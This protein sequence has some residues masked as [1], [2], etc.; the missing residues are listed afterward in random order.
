MTVYA[1]PSGREVARV[2]QIPRSRFSPAALAVFALAS[3][4]CAAIS[5]RPS[6][7]AEAPIATEKN[8]PGDIPDSQIFILY[9]SP[10]GFTVEVPEGWGRKERADGASFADKYGLLEVS[11][12]ATSDDPTLASV[13]ANEAM[14]LQQSGHAVKID[15][16]E[17]VKLPAGPAILIKYHSNSEANAVSNKKIRLEH[18]RY[19]IGHASKLATIDFSAPAGADNVDQWQ[20]MSQSFVWN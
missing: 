20:L 11:L 19:L 12:S 18:D 1:R 6:L 5:P 7:A 16:I 3:F 9:R 17:A 15:A 10:L 8:P 14:A 13:K 2:E 4:S